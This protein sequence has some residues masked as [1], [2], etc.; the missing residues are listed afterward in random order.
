[1]CTSLLLNYEKSGAGVN[2]WSRRGNWRALDA[3]RAIK[4]PIQIGGRE[5]NAFAESS[6]IKDVG[7]TLLGGDC[8]IC[9]RRGHVLLPRGVRG[10]NSHSH[11]EHV[12]ACPGMSEYEGARSALLQP[13]VHLLE[14]CADLQ[15]SVKCTHMCY[16]ISWRKNNNIS[17]GLCNI[18]EK[19][20]SFLLDV[21]RRNKF[22]RCERVEKNE[23]YMFWKQTFRA[24][25]KTKISKK[26]KKTRKICMSRNPQIFDHI[27]VIRTFIN[28]PC[29]R[30]SKF[31]VIFD[32]WLQI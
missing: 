32:I 10:R 31:N 7:R 15:G 12:A 1:M 9:S 28:G 21:K 2:G 30:Y 16:I 6:I 17:S 14:M 20:L 5:R 8:K 26:L 24:S 29:S 4:F 18:K 11:D 3:R 22:I 25:A 23:S 13:H 19:E 27:M